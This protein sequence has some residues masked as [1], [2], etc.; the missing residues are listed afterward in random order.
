MRAQPIDSYSLITDTKIDGNGWIPF[1]GVAQ[2]SGAVG[3]TITVKN[4]GVYGAAANRY[5]AN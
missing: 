2:N 5:V 3:D 4:Y 1:I